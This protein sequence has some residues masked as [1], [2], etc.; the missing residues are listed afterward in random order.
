VI[1]GWEA[2]EFPTSIHEAMTRSLLFTTGG[3]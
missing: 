1:C 2:A 3:G